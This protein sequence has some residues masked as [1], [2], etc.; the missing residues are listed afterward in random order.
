MADSPR[1]I[2]ENYKQKIIDAFIQSIEKNGKV[3]SGMLSQSVSVNIRAFATNMVIEVEME[4][5]WKFVDGGVDGWGQN[6]KGE[7][8]YKKD[9]KIIP[10]Q[11]M[12]KH[13]KNRGLTPR[14][15]NLKKARLERSL[16]NKTVKKALKQK[17]KA[18]Q[19]TSMAFALGYN[20]KKHG[21]KPTNFV[22]E[23]LESDVFDNL[24]RDISVA[25]G[26]EILIDFNLE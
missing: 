10:I 16:K 20:L 24:T 22:N 25:L 17:N 26:R 9:G 23:A 1:Q 5:Y 2:L 14:A 12:L 21:L 4:K 8:K 19:Y 18:D 7:F 11:A 3:A 15:T 13:I 6:N